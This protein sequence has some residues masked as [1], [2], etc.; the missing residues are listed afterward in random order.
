M[1][2]TATVIRKNIEAKKQRRMEII[3]KAK[4]GILSEKE[5]IEYIWD[6]I[7]STTST[8][9]PIVDIPFRISD[10]AYE[11]FKSMLFIIIRREESTTISC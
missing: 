6:M 8:T 10:K 3:N 9:E 2:E 5:E 7:N 1:F 11:L 4:E